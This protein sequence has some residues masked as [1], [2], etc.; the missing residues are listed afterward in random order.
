MVRFREELSV[1]YQR[2]FMNHNDTKIGKDYFI[3]KL[4]EAGVPCYTQSPRRPIQTRRSQ[5][6]LN[7]AVFPYVQFIHPEFQRIH[8]WFQSQTITQTKGAFENINATING[9]KFVFGLGGIHGSVE[10][11]IVESDDEY[12][13][14]DCDVASYYPSLAIANRVFPEHLSVTFCD[15]YKDVFDQRRSHAKGTAENAMLKLALNGVYGD[16]N[17]QYSPFY[18]SLYTMKITINGQLLL[19]MLS[20]HLMQIPGLTMI[21]INTDG[22]TVKMPR[23]AR[24]MYDLL[25][26]WWQDFTCLT[27]EFVEYNR[28]MVRDVNSYIAEY[29][30]GKLKRKGAYGYGSDLDWSQNHS[31]QVIAKAAEAALVR[32]EDVATFIKDH[33]DIH[34]FMLRTKVPRSSKLMLG[35]KQVQNITR[36]YI[37]NDGDALVKVMPP[38]PTQVKKDPNAPDRRIGINVGWM[39]T[40]CNNI[41]Q[42][43]LFN[44]NYDYYIQEC[45][46]LVEVLR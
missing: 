30:D 29:T 26:Q 13:L 6:H 21:Q 1:K 4:E 12:V 45:N 24:P 38:T 41:A 36:Y 3:M 8:R 9:F 31:S 32:G 35:D 10:S 20:E 11:Q 37:T 16:S 28:M 40:E 43:S 33:G 44:I 27:L 17:N 23:S 22:L 46:K 18:D 39:A 42:A 15:I 7:E 2:N 19:C 5:I 25:C 34:D 14:V